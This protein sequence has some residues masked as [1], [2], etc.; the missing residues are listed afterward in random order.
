MRTT[1]INIK[2]NQLVL[3]RHM[4]IDWQQEYNYNL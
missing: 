4:A 3:I 2:G 1:Y